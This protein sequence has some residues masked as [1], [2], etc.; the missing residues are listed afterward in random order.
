MTKALPLLAMFLVAICILPVA[1]FGIGFASV[2]SAS[3]A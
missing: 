2:V 1:A 3:R